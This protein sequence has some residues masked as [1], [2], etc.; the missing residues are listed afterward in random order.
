MNKIRVKTLINIATI[1]KVLNLSLN[2]LSLLW[3]L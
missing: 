3:L 1:Q 2:L